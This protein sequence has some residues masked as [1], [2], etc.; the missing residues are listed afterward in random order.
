MD[1]NGNEIKMVLLDILRIGLLRIRVLGIG[2][3]AERCSIEADHLHNLPHL[4]QSFNQDELLY[5]FDVERPCFLAHA[6]SSADEFSVHW[7]RLA[8]LIDSRNPA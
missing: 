2:G 4:I 3:S 5:Y 8:A 6:K 7:D 1:D